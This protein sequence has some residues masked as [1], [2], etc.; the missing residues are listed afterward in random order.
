MESSNAITKQPDKQLLATYVH[1]ALELETQKHILKETIFISLDRKVT[2]ERENKKKCDSLLSSR[3]YTLEDHRKKFAD[4]QA[5]LDRITSTYNEKRSSLTDEIQFLESCN[6]KAFRKK[7]P[8]KATS[9]LWNLIR[10]LPALVVCGIFM[11]YGFALRTG[12]IL[13]VVP[14]RYFPKP[15]MFSIPVALYFLSSFLP[16]I[17]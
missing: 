4:T 1:D 17:A 5:T 12:L 7:Y 6:I 14:L 9:P 8:A 16:A 10:F 15:S 13:S 3:Q 11:V 2:A